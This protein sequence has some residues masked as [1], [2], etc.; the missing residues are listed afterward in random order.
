MLEVVDEP[1]EKRRVL[2]AL[3]Q[4]FEADRAAPWHFA[5]AERQRDALVGAIVAFR[6]RVRHLT[7][8]FKLSQNRPVVDQ[9]RIAAALDAEPY[10]DAAAVAAWMRAY[11]AANSK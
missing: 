1:V 6:M 11:G 5:M 4:R 3:V 10:A 8:K 2:D 9:Q 7:G